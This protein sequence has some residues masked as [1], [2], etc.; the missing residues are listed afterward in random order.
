MYALIALRA[1]NSPQLYFCTLH[2]HK[3]R[4]VEKGI[5]LIIQHGQE[6][7]TKTAGA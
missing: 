7:I 6:R 1:K 5:K 3:D 4:K 2:P